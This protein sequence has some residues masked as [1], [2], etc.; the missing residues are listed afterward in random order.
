MADSLH[1]DE[2]TIV[3]EAVRAIV[4]YIETNGKITFPINVTETE[5][6]KFYDELYDRLVAEEQAKF[7][8]QK[9]TR[10]P[11]KGDPLPPQ[12]DGA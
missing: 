9:K 8:G 12:Q 6:E 3:R 10:A 7:G 1:I 11:R 4:D 5:K 2:A